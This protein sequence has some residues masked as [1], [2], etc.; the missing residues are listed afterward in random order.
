MG[1]SFTKGP[2]SFGIEGGIPVY[3]N[4]NGLQPGTNWLLTVGGQVM[5]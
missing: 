1:T 5:F 4:V 3:E 2:F